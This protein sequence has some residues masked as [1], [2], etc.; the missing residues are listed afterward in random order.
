[1]RSQGIKIGDHVEIK[2]PWTVS[3]DTT[4][5]SLVEIGSHV[6][7]NKGFTLLTH[8]FAAMV[9]RHVYKEFIGSSG[10]VTIGS[11]VYFGWHCTVM[12][13]VKIGDNCIIGAHSVVV[14]DIPS[15]SVAV[16]N[17]AK[18]I[19]SIEDYYKKRKEA[20]VNE[21]LDYAR[22]IYE[23]YGRL[24]VMEEFWEEFP[25]F[26]KREELPSEIPVRYQLG[27]AYDHYRQNHIPLFDSFEQFLAASGL[28][29]KQRDNG[30]KNA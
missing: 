26:L 22:S 28:D 30:T 19:S 20:S 2:K 27:P 1:L 23:K 9:L 16:G 10:R 3:I 15:N 11:N 14:K 4:R 17:P 8:D 13:G 5:P 24:P 7:I 18:V 6:R 12:K 29:T 21:A 25:F